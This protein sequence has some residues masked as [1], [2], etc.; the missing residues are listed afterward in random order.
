LSDGDDLAAAAVLHGD[1]L[2]VAGGI[3]AAGHG[4]INVAVFRLEME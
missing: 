3:T 2:I 1:K 4:A